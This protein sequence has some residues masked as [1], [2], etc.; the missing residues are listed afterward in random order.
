MPLEVIIFSCSYVDHI[1]LNCQ[2]DG[3][4]SMEAITIVTGVSRQIK[5]DQ[6]LF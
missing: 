6:A 1:D 4:V 5:Y 2:H 3:Y